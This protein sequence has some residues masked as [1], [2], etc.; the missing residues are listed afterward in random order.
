VR[1]G[2]RGR[3]GGGGK[4]PCFKNSSYTVY[5]AGMQNVYRFLPYRHEGNTD[6]EYLNEISTDRLGNRL[7]LRGEVSGDF[8]KFCAIGNS[9]IS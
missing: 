3:G 1:G 8:L 7:V 4:S 6:E 9:V 5:F 2:G